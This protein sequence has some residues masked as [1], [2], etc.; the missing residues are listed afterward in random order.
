MCGTFGMFMENESGD[1]YCSL[2]ADLFELLDGSE[3][4]SR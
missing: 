2:D 4:D 3:S 1:L